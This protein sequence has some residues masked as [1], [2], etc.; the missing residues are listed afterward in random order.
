MS[1]TQPYSPPKWP[2]RFLRFFVKKEYLEEIEGDMEEI[3]YEYAEYASVKKARRMYTWE[4]IKLFRPILIKNLEILQQLN[5]LDMFKNYFKVSMRGLVKNPLN[6]FINVFGLS[7]SIGFAVF[8]YAFFMWTIS[9]DQF[10]VH[11]NEVHMVTAFAERDGTMQQHGKTPQPLGDM[12]KHDFAQINKVCRVEDKNVVMK[13]E[14]RVHHERVRFTDPEFLE[15]LTFPLKWGTIGSLKDLNSII[16]S[17]DMS[18]KY[19]GEENPI[20]QSMV[21]IFEKGR[22]KEFKITGVAKEFPKSRTITFNF[23]INF[24]NLKSAT[25]NYNFDDWTASI[26]ST[27]IQIKP[28]D[29][30][31]IKKGMEKYKTIQNKAVG[32]DWAIS[33]FGFEPLATLHIASE[34]IREGISR[35][36]KTNYTSIRFMVVISF[37]L[38]VLACF[39]YINIA[40]AT[41]AKRLKEIGIRKSIGATRRKV[42][43]QFLSENVVITFFALI[44]GLI[45]GYTFFIPGF[46]FL[47]S[48]NLDFRVWD[49]SLWMFLA[50]IL[51]FTS[52]ASGIYPSIYISRFQ[53]VNIL[54]GS[55][56][57]GQRNPVTKFFLGFQLAM[58]CIF[59]TCSVLFKM[60]NTYMTERPWGYNQAETLYAN[61]PDGAAYEELNLLMAQQPD[62]ISIS[63]SQHHVGKSHVPTVLHFPERELEVDRLAVDPAYF[64]TM[65]IDLIDGRTFNHAEGSDRQAVVVNEQLA[66]SM[67]WTS[68]LGEQFRID[69]IQ[70]EVIG[71]VKD[72]HSYSFTKQIRP[73]IFTIADKKEYKY[74]SLKVKSGSEISV[75]ESLQK[76]WAKLF[77][78]IPFEGG[79]QEDVWGFYFQ[80]LKIYDLVWKVLAFIAVSL[81]TLGL[82]GLVKL[83]VEGRTKEFSIRKVLGAGVKS[84]AGCIINQYM[85]L[86]IVAIAIGS[87]LGFFFGRW[88]I[89]GNAYHM[90]VTLY[91]A[92]IAV[93]IIIIVLLTTISTQVWKVLKTNPVNGLKSE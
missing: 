40:I 39:N 66:K 48:V 29:L 46:E 69:T 11:K 34:D 5:Q 84:I 70:Y 74:L 52:I 31:S 35:S 68:A 26:N 81:A 6:S 2:L 14:D 23:L 64:E 10:H 93:V 43:V 9:V 67:A 73:V 55:M 86:F 79:H 7:M 85:I 38:L 27:L 33:S 8:S 30:E 61:V 65:G 54:K 92:G 21:M 32:E 41:A 83:N 71:V 47:W 90:P 16:L 4:I 42:I 3:F 22:S 37:F 60:N 13:Y 44:V 76:N 88:L 25:P 28:S 45:L 20:G 77:P 80:T 19:F 58:S 82:Y 53:V 15:M 63:G 78:E 49:P 75:Q 87:P 89:E 56:K 59:I 51:L 12:L 91:P 17:E 24:E 57:F 1:Q 18:I 36:S 50:A 62:V 72:F